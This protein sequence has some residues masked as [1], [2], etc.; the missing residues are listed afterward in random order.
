[1]SRALQIFPENALSDRF[2]RI[3]NAPLAEPIHLCIERA[4]LITA[5][6]QYGLPDALKDEIPARNRHDAGRCDW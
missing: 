1:M 3:R 6:F 4:L 2:A 5:D